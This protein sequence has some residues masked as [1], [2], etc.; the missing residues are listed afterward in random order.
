MMRPSLKD[1]LVDLVYPSEC[2][3]CGI[4]CPAALCGPCALSM[5]RRAVRSESDLARAG[6]P[7]AFLG[8][9][10]AGEYRGS[11]KDMVLRLKDS[12]RRLASPLAALMLAAAGNDPDYLF[13]SALFCV[14]STTEKVAKRGYNQSRLLAQAY[15]GLAGV[16]VLDG[17]RVAGKSADQDSVPGRAR[18]ANVAGA[19]SFSGVAPAGRVLLIDDVMTTGAT[20]DACSHLL[21][22]AGACSVRVLVAARAVLRR[23]ADR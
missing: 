21:L 15:S 17:L 9:R 14:P 1:H 13:P 4:P 22:D 7:V 3:N 16:P 23:G 10:A 5:A 18:W 8:W 12:E 2:A 20:A 11:L 6:R 19:F